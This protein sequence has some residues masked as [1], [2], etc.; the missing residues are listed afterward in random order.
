[1]LRALIKSE[2]FAKK[3]PERAKKVVSN[4]TGVQESEVARLWPDLRLEI[5]IEQPFLISLENE[6]RW[7]IRNK[8]TDRKKVPNY[9]N[10]I[11]LDAL[12]A[13]RPKGVSIIR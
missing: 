4:K 8:L 1:V 13:V 5:S 6:A 7:V 3:H 10:F 2:E 9:L 12:E 11:Y